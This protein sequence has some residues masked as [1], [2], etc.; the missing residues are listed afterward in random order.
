[1]GQHNCHNN[2]AAKILRITYHFFA[3][4]IY[5][6]QCLNQNSTASYNRVSLWYDPISYDTIYSI[7]TTTVHGDV[8]KWKHLPRYWPLVRGIHWPL[9]DSSHK[10]QWRG[11]LMFSLMAWANNQYIGDLRHHRA[12][13][14]VTVIRNTDYS[15]SVFIDN[16]AEGIGVEYVDC[17]LLTV[18]YELV[19]YLK[20]ATHLVSTHNNRVSKYIHE[21]CSKQCCFYSHIA[22]HNCASNYPLLCGVVITTVTSSHQSPTESLCI[23]RVEA[24]H[25]LG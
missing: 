17:V 4:D 24:V 10:D 8:I 25:W 5:H 9:V 18:V 20:Y 12:H 21:C 23:H 6:Q 13:Y 7:M 3:N 22:N 2:D 16:E 15:G 1:M 14:G 19:R 11:A